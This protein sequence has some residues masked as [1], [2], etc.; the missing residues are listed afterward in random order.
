MSSANTSARS[1]WSSYAKA[2][3][4]RLLGGKIAVEIAGAHAGLVGDVLHRRGVKAVAHEGALGRGEDAR[5]PIRVGRARG[6]Q[7]APGGDRMENVVDPRAT[8]GRT[9]RMNVH[10]HDAR[11]WRDFCG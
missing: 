5:A 7:A 10:S 6:G 9:M 1:A 2:L 4:H 3:D 8:I 11:L